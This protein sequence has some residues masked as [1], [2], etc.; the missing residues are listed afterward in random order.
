MHPPHQQLVAPGPVP[1]GLDLSYVEQLPPWLTFDQ[2]GRY[3]MLRE[4]LAAARQPLDQSR[5]SVLDVGGWIRHILGGEG[6][7]ILSFLPDD[8]VLVVD[9]VESSLPHYRR[10]DGAQL[11]FF[12]DTFDFVTSADTLEHIPAQRR[13]DFLRELMRVARFG[14]VLV[15]P[16]GHPAVDAAEELLLGYIQARLGYVQ[17]Q[18][19]E[20]REYGL[21]DLAGTG[22]HFSRAGHRWHVYPSGY[23]HSW[24]FMMMAKHDLFGLT[25]DAAI[26][27]RVDQYYIRWLAAGERREP[28]Y[29]HCFVVAKNNRSDWLR[30]VDAAL[31]ATVQPEGTAAIG[32]WQQP[33][34][35]LIDLLAIGQSQTKAPEQTIA[36]QQRHIDEL[37]RMLRQREA[38]VA[39]LERRAAWLG[40]QLD[41]TRWQLQRV[42]NGTA[43]RL[44]NSLRR[45]R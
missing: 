30:E 28:S 37:Q 20:H 35:W 34:N 6:L 7:P 32:D 9:Q 31:A 21:P 42:A 10:G 8:D 4:A 5:F 19:A 23:I 33:V 36:A 44:L 3:S 39:D 17:Q 38:E 45:K 27:T 29:R 22:E 14:I 2:F 16:F 11:D 12:D 13:D 26:H 24:L 43:M 40:Q 25:D 18:L 41:Q 1:P 15:A